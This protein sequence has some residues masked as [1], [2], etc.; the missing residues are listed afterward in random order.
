MSAVQDRDDQIRAIFDEIA[1][2]LIQ[3]MREKP[4]SMIF[5]CKIPL[6]LQPIPTHLSIDGKLTRS[7]LT[8]DKS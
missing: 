3:G 5:G 6:L 7:T 4:G 2:G 8:E 1:E